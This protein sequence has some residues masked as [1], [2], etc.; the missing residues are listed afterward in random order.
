MRRSTR[1]SRSWPAQAP[2]RRCA[3]CSNAAARFARRS[4]R[5]GRG[6]CSPRPPSAPTAPGSRRS[7]HE[8]G[9]YDEALAI[10]HGL[11]AESA[12]TG[13]ADGYVF[14]EIGENLLAQRQGD[15]AKPYFAR[16]WQVLSAA[17][18]LDRPDDSHLARLERLSR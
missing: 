11:E 18:S 4:C 8:A 14:E 17:T 7:L 16:A 5:N 2:S 13:G 9:R 6:R 10:L 3:G 1:S 15:A 12:A